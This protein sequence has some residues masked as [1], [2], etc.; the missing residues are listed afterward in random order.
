MSSKYNQ[1]QI[2]FGEQPAI[3][4]INTDNVEKTPK[5][6]TPKEM[7]QHP[8]FLIDKT[9]ACKKSRRGYEALKLKAAL[10]KQGVD[11]ET[12]TQKISFIYNPADSFY[13]TSKN[14]T[15]VSNQNY[16]LPDSFDGLVWSYIELFISDIYIKS[17][18]FFYFYYI[19]PSDIVNY[20]INKGLYKKSG[21]LYSNVRDSIYRLR[22]TSYE[23]VEG[24]YNKETDTKLSKY[25]LSLIQS[26]Y[27][28][29]S[30][31]PDGSK[32]TSFAIAV[33]P[34]IVLNFKNNHFLILLSEYRAKIKSH[35]TI[36]LFNRLSYLAFNGIISR[37]FT[38]ARKFKFP[39]VIVLKYEF[40]CEFLGLT[41]LNDKDCKPSHIIRQL[42]SIIDEL[43]EINCLY[44]VHIDKSD[45]STRVVFCL[46]GDFIDDATGLL[47]KSAG[48][49]L[50][51]TP[52]MAECKKYFAKMK[53]L[54]LSD[55]L[56]KTLFNPE[57]ID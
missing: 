26:I 12:I 17:G 2:S 9:D 29:G 32:A 34:L 43:I 16:G 14:W 36:A 15:I 40:I 54:I 46:S 28:Q 23:Y 42:K 7:G 3:I 55:K 25:T 19:D 27:E 45:N 4:Q 33:E 39:F 21:K 53:S 44:E 52:S 37:D 8:F 38:I 6:Y 56:R 5:I 49:E 10:E 13:T 51:F 20:L 48:N 18:K 41:P 30:T 31:L 57:L 24:F 47:S 50:Q 1:L 22:Y 35:P 11:K